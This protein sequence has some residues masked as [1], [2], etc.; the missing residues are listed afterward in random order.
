[1]F[2]LVLD[3]RVL[4]TTFMPAYHSYPSPT[5]MLIYNVYACLYFLI[6]A[7]QYMLSM[8]VAHLWLTFMF[9]FSST[10]LSTGWRCVEIR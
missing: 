6:C 10:H 7:Y 2:Q 1:M 9:Q 4:P 5:Y 3:S 8:S